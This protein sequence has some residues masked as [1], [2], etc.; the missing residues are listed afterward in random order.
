MEQNTQKKNGK[1][2]TNQNNVKNIRKNA[3]MMIKQKDEPYPIMLK[4]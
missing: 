1:K 2:L 4:K 3:Q